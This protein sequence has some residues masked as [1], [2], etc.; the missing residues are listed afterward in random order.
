MN[1]NEDCLF[2]NTNHT[3][4]YQLHT[5]IFI[6]KTWK[7]RFFIL[8]KIRDDAYHLRYYERKEKKDKP[9]GTIDM[10]EY[11]HLLPFGT[12]VLC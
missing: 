11:A 5:L 7:W 3:G 4:N 9:L 2:S 8:V 6:Q 10:S 12:M 1:T